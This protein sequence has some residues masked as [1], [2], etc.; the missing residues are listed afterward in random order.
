M[1]SPSVRVENYVE[2]TEPITDRFDLV[3]DGRDSFPKLMN[4]ELRS[5]FV[6]ENKC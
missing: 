6:G 5:E 4:F 3:R 1:I 2:L